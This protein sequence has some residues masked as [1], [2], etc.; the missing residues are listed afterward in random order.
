[1][2]ELNDRPARGARE[3]GSATDGRT[4]RRS[5]YAA[6]QVLLCCQLDLCGAEACLVLDHLDALGIVAAGNGRAHSALMDD[7]GRDRL[8]GVHRGR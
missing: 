2:S 3:C 7:E 1:M 4:R 6:S 8:L 5:G